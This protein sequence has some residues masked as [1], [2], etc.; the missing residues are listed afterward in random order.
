M[1]SK[2][3]LNRSP[4]SF[5]V[6]FLSYLCTVSI[7]KWYRRNI[8]VL[9]WVP[10]TCKNSSFFSLL[11]HL[12][13]S[14]TQLCHSHFQECRECCQRLRIRTFPYRTISFSGQL[15]LE[16]YTSKNM[17]RRWWGKK[18]PEAQLQ[19]RGIEAPLTH[20]KGLGRAQHITGTQ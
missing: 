6:L 8:C 1:I 11:P 7:C 14:Q 20:E 4:Y 13:W 18:G 2:W 10:I 19:E 12:A 9:N 16:S 5:S 3:H 15:L 17:R